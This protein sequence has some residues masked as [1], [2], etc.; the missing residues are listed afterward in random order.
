MPKSYV[1]LRWGIDLE[2]ETAKERVTRPLLAHAESLGLGEAEL[3]TLAPTAEPVWMESDGDFMVHALL[4]RVQPVYNFVARCFKSL[5]DYPKTVIRAMRYF[6][7]QGV[8]LHLLSVGRLTPHADA[9]SELGSL[10][11]DA[12]AEV[13]RL[14]DE[15]ATAREQ[16]EREAHELYHQ[17]TLEFLRQHKFGAS[18]F[19]PPPPEP[20]NKPEEARYLRHIR[21]AKGLSQKELAAQIGADQS[22]VSRAET[23]GSGALV[24]KII[25]ALD[26]DCPDPDNPISVKARATRVLREAEDLEL[27]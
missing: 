5:S 11:E 25:R 16:A 27:A 18:L 12:E 22:Q 24:P 2:A 1:L 19:P 26:P 8:N 15:A 7:G 17:V 20:E 6:V 13:R 10:M 3:I 21:K 23:T 4:E 9:L 14:K